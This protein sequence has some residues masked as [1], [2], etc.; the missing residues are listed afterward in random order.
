MMLYVELRVYS[1]VQTVE[2]AHDKNVKPNLNLVQT[3]KIVISQI[4]HTLY[5][6]K[7]PYPEMGDLGN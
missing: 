2:I 1:R 4:A 7:I 6:G 5:F 3:V